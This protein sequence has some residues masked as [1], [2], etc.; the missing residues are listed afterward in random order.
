[1]HH[2][3]PLP[4]SAPGRLEIINMTPGLPVLSPRDVNRSVEVV[5]FLVACSWRNPYW[6]RG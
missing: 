5:T 3:M 2:L 4:I 1:M 6:L